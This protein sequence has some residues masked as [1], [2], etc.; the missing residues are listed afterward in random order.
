MFDDAVFQAETVFRGVIRDD[1]PFAA[2]A[3]PALSG[4][5]SGVVADF[6]I[7]SV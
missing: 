1:R 2:I 3:V 6:A 7:H 4:I 5:V